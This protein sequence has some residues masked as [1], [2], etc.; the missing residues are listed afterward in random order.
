MCPLFDVR[1]HADGNA[2]TAGMVL[3][4]RFTGFRLGWRLGIAAQ[5]R[6]LVFIGNSET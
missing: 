2:L 4:F 5:L 6:G 1:A 3:H